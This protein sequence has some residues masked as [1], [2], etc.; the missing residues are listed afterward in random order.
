LA[1]VHLAWSKFGQGHGV[2]PA[3]L[4]R[5]VRFR[6]WSELIAAGWRGPLQAPVDEIIYPE[7]YRAWTALARHIRCVPVLL[8][9]W[10]SRSLPLQPCLCDVWHDHLLFEGDALTGLIDIGAV[11][12]DH[13]AVDL[14]RMLGSLVGDDLEAWNRGLAAYRR[15]RGLSAEEEALAEVLDRTGTILAAAN[16]LW[17][18][19]R[20]RREYEDRAGVARRLETLVTRM[21]RWS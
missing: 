16:W 3:L 1:Q 15:V 17:W 6:E 18:L 21:E 10:T 20:D 5:L 9:A 4:R 7:A 8:Q 11:K 13:V 2:C 12:T 19:Y 14:A